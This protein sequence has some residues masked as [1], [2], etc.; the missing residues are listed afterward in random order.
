[1]R[2]SKQEIQERQ[3]QV[4]DLILKGYKDSDIQ[5]ELGLTKIVVESDKAVISANY[6][7]AVTENKFLLARQA[8]HIMKH[9][10][11]LDMIKQ[12]LWAIEASAPAVDY[13]A[14]LEALKTLIDELEHE[15]KILR[16][17][18]T[19][20]TII[21]N[22]IHIDKLNILMSKLTEVVNEFVPEDRRQYA[23]QRIKD[24]GPILDTE[25]SAVVD[26]VEKA[27]GTK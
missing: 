25:C 5:K 22:Y 4:R 16:L 17:I 10:E 15:S 11:Q 9:L 12:K 23:F 7:K 21:K 27:E 2:K 19:S 18:D 20:H 26:E 13:K 8:E 24:L 14:K 6:V 1:M 3:D